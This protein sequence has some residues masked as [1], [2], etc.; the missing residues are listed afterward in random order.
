MLGFDIFLD[1]NGKP[2]LLEIN[3]NPS[4]KLPTSLDVEIKTAALAGCL[5]IVCDK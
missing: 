2:H 3:H 4:F 5:A 1:K